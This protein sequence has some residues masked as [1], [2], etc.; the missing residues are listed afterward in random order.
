[1]ANTVGFVKRPLLY[2]AKDE[3]KK[4]ST[5]PMSAKVSVVFKVSQKTLAL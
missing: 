3:Y 4:T 1:M 2:E 5:T